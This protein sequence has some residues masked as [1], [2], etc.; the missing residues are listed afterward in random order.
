MPGH[1]RAALNWNTLRRMN[2]DAYSTEMTDGMKIIVCKLKQNPLGYTSIA[3]PIDQLRLP[4]WFQDLPFDHAAMESTVIDG[5]IQNLLGVLNWDLNT[6][7]N[8]ENTFQS[9]FEFE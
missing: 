2:S 7:T 5:K 4:Q 6:Q 3:Y 8:T 9:L 1:V